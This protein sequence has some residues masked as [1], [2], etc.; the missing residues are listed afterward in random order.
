MLKSCDLEYVVSSIEV[1]KACAKSRCLTAESTLAF[2]Y[3]TTIVCL[4][5]WLEMI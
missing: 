1:P 4:H 5:E 2:I 3:L